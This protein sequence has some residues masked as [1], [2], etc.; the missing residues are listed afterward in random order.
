MVIITTAALLGL[1]IEVC[2][3]AAINEQSKSTIH[4]P[5]AD[6]SHPLLNDW[7]GYSI[8]PTAM[9]PYVESKIAFNILQSIERI[10]GQSASIRVGGTTSDE[11]RFANSV[12]NTSG[13]Q[14]L[15]PSAQSMNNPVQLITTRWY[16]TWKDY[17]PESTK[18]IYT[19]NFGNTTNNWEI[20]KKE[21][22]LVLEA[23][24]SKLER[25]EL[26]NEIDHY[27]TFGWRKQG[28]DVAQY[29]EQYRNLTAALKSRDSFKHANPTPLFQ[30]GVIADPPLVPDQQ[31][32]VD[33]FS[34]YN[35]TT[36]GH[37]T[38]S[39]HSISSYA[40]HLYPQSTCDP[41]RAARLSLDLLSDH[42]VLYKNV[43]QYIPQQEAAQRAGAPL[44]FGET[45]SVSC[46][47]KS[48]ISDTFG[49]TLWT[50]DYALMSASL[51]IPQI[52]FHLG[53]QSE[54]SAFTPLPYEHKGEQ[55]QAGVRANLYG[56]LFAAYTLEGLNGHG[57]VK[58]L[59]DANSSDLSGYAIYDGS[60]SL[61]KIALLDMGVWNS[62]QGISNPSTVSSTDSHSASQGKRPKKQF[63]LQTSW[64]ENSIVN[65]LRLQAPGTNAKSLVNVSGQTFDSETGTLGAAPKPEKVKVNRDGTVS[66]TLKRAEAV[67]LSV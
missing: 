40:V 7:F 51:N 43:S 35:L 59:P 54:Y 47:G 60:K 9:G 58:A 52:F 34:I 8:E 20:A 15:A 14:T 26:G 32:E 67:L 27:I 22:D 50:Y 57:T 44:V 41:E 24:K 62:T 39:D 46:G 61:K 53:D 30:A 6:Q 10:I 56:H 13:L 17:F 1:L 5:S 31:D 48:G 12:N 36:K 19:L 3:A 65:L 11:I 64:K 37:L 29:V 21:T 38:N 49:A 55:L 66:V 2:W 23:L 25:F 33:D 28:W 4:I 18:F 42:L 45:N 63:T 16:D